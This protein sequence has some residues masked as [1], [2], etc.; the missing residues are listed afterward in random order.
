MKRKCSSELAYVLGILLVAFGGMLMEKANFGVSMVT[1][2]AYVLYR[3]LSPT[4]HFVTFG[5]AIYFVEAVILALMGLII[6]KFRIT[7]L[8][9]LVTA[10]IFGR[11]L[12]VFVRLG[13]VLPANYLWQRGIYYVAGMLFSAAGV[14]AMFHTYIAPEVYELFVKEV[15]ARFHIEI[16]RFKTFY[17]CVSCLVAVLMSFIAFG[18]WH[19]VGVKWGTILCALVNGTIIGRFSAFYEKHLTFYDKFPFRRFFESE[20]VGRK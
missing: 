11:V 4:W 1:A 12:D 6:R 3:W 15:S 13:T 14:S 16:T 7:H 8:F 17:D 9:S 2:P 18:M 10:A 5:K 19:F 20:T